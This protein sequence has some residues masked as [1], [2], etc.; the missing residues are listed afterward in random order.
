M[1]TGLSTSLKDYLPRN[2]GRWVK[3]W[4]TKKN[5]VRQ[6]Q[7][8]ESLSVSE[9]LSKASNIHDRGIVSVALSLMIFKVKKV[10]GVRGG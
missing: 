6:H 2:N 3:A 8:M 9:L 7:G 5:M 10:E 4:T 1:Q